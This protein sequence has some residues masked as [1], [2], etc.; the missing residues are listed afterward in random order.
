MPPMPDLKALVEAVR[1]APGLL[2]KRDVRIVERLR[3]GGKK[4]ERL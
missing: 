4:K 1:S 3:R 2:G